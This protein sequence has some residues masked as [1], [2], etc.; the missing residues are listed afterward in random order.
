MLREIVAV[1][2][3]QKLTTRHSNSL[4]FLLL[5]DYENLYFPFKVDC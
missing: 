5:L 2:G 3:R 4:D 1:L